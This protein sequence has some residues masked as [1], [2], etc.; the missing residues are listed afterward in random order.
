LRYSLAQG[1]IGKNSSAR[2]EKYLE[3]KAAFTWERG[4]IVILA[5]RT[6]KMTPP[7]TSAMR[8]LANDLKRS[9]VDVINF[10]AGELDGDASDLMKTAAKHAIDEGCNKYT[11]TL[12]TKTLRERVA[13]QVSARCGVH[14]SADEIGVSAGAKQAL[15]NAAMVLFNPGDEVVIPKP[16]WVTFPAQVQLAGA[17]PVFVD[18]ARTGYQLDSEDL[19]RVIT[20]ATKA[21]IINSPNNPTGVI[22]EPEELRRI[23]QIAFER[24]IWIIFDEC[25]SELVR[26]GA[27]HRNVVQLV[28]RIK[29]QTILINSFSKSHAVT[30]WRIGYACGPK[31]VIS[32]M[33]NFQ[34]HTTSNAC[35]ISQHAAAAALQQDDGQFIKNVNA[36]LEQRLRLAMSTIGSMQEISCAPANGAFYLFLNV[37]QKFGKRYRGQL[38]DNVGKLCE[39][40]LKESN[41]AVV[42]G[43]AFGDPT[44]I[45]VSYA[46]AT[47]QVEEGLQRMKRLLDNIV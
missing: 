29:G 14:Y 5:D 47:N 39:L 30:G 7:G 23:S 9:G 32:A 20:P 19:E 15:Y 21:V 38:I 25:Y 24:K 36:V 34:G 18:T 1:S 16:Y 11:P 44:G 41:V 10:A 8:E 13:E 33:G 43:D 31:H 45:R 12:G 4:W 37:A 35:T 26:V 6:I 40:L 17:S 28:E 27:K 3:R 22:Y 42:P 46:I 2:L